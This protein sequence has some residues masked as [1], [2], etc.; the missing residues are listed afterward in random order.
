MSSYMDMYYA[1]INKQP[2]KFKSPQKLDPIISSPVHDGPGMFN[3]D[4]SAFYFTRNNEEEIGRNKAVGIISLAVYESKI[5]DGKFGTPR[6]LEFNGKAYSCA[7]PTVNKAGNIIVFTSDIGGGFG[8]KDLYYSEFIDST[9]K[10]GKPVNLGPVINTPGG[11]RYPFS[12]PMAPCTSPVMATRDMAVPT[13]S[14]PSLPGKARW[15][16]PTWKTW[17]SPSTHNMMISVLSV[18]PN[19]SPGISLPIVRAEGAVMTCTTL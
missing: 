1:E 13:F 2:W 10:W 4:G 19:T 18:M 9:G 16:S 7:H 5:T 14:G 3:H 6:L 8:G 15:N 11:E 17:A 12:I